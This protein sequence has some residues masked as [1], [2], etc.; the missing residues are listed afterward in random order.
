MIIIKFAYFLK[1]V[2]IVNKRFKKKL[3]GH[4]SKS[5]NFKIFTIY[6]LINKNYNKNDKKIAHH[7]FFHIN[8]LPTTVIFKFKNN[9]FYFNTISVPMWLQQVKLFT[10]KYISLK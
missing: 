5:S 4:N 1:I 8:V 7:F 10:R 9:T 2:Q 6:L 3:L